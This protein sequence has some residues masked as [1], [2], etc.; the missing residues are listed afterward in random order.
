[1]IMIIIIKKIIIIT[2][3]IIDI[4]IIW[5]GQTDLPK[6]L[7]LHREVFHFIDWKGLYMSVSLLTVR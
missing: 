6:C 5:G 1:M 2:V 3:I 7:H 4:L